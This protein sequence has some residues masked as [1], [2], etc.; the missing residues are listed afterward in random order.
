MANIIIIGGGVAGLSAGIYAQL[1]G[2]HATIYERHFKAGGNLTAW[3]RGGYHIDN[4]IHWLTGTNPVTKLYKMWT[5]LGALGNVPVYQ[6]ESF[7]T[8]EKDGYTLSLGQSIDK[9]GEDML[10]ISPNDRKEISAFVKAV[11]AFHR[12][13]GIAGKNNDEKATSG[14]KL[15]AIPSVMR[16]YGLTTGELAKRFHHPVISGFIESMMTDYFSAL[17]LIMVFATFTGGNGGIPEGSSSAMAERMI[18]RFLSLGGKLQLRKGIAKIN[19]NKDTAESVT[20]DD[21]TTATADYVIVATDPAVTFGKLLSKKLMPKALKKQYNNPRMDRFSSYHCAYS[22]DASEL[23]FSGD[24]MLEVPQEYRTE[25][26]TDYLLLREF[27]HEKSFAPEGK[28]ILQTMI[29]CKEAEARKFISLSKDKSAYKAK[30]KRISEI[31]SKIITDKFPSLREKVNCIDVWTPATYRRYVG[32]E[33]GSWMA[34]ALPPKMIP[35]KLDNRVKGLKNVILATQ[36]LQTPG[37]LPIAAS[38][39]KRAIQAILEQEKKLAGT[40]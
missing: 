1:N 40:T 5:D 26:P 11:K 22:C 7:F 12:I 2:H 31:I 34:F 33:M 14:Q 15:R 9:L 28:N 30:K 4:C 25:L 18:N 13:N 39:G 19:T 17:A 6:A 36:W 8:F 3:E 21:G 35:K 27:S 10:A 38:S 20:F 23:P 16:Y 29:Y 24:I 37:G 32:S